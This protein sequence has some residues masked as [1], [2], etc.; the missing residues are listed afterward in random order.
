MAQSADDRAGC[1][2]RGEF[3]VGD[4]AFGTDDERDLAGAVDRDVEERPGRRL[5][6]HNRLPAR[7]DDRSEPRGDGSG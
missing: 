6:Q 4:A 2:E 3:V 7:A 5:V 1:F